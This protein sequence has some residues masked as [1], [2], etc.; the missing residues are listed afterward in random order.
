VIF[1]DSLGLRDRLRFHLRRIAARILPAPSVPS[2]EHKRAKI[3]EIAKKFGCG[4]FVETG[5][6]VGDTVAY[7]VPHFRSIISIEL[8]HELAERAQRR[9]L[10]ESRVQILE[11]DSSE[12]LRVIVPTL[13]ERGFFWLDGHYSHSCTVDGEPLETARGAED[14]PVLKELAVVLAD[15]T[16]DHVILIDDARLFTGEG[17]YPTRRA[18]SRV[19]R[20]YNRG[21]EIYRE[22]D[23]IIVVPPSAIQGGG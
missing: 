6:F 16:H 2:S 21:Y 20:S 1:S 4:I 23:V 22:D 11:G 17:Q 18:I 7:M 3:L 8:S 12:M 13:Q 9:F 15:E 19:V 5:T 10:R 14:T